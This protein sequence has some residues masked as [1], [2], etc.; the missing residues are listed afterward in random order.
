MRS[1]WSG[2]VTICSFN[3][4]RDTIFTDHISPGSTYEGVP[5]IPFLRNSPV[6]HRSTGLYLMHF[7]GH[8]RQFSLQYAEGFPYP[9][10][11]NAPADGKELSAEFI[12]SSSFV[13]GLG[14]LS[15]YCSHSS[16]IP[17]KIK[18]TPGHGLYRGKEKKAGIYRET[19]SRKG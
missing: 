14:F 3:S 8:I 11:G 19:S 4:S 18:S 13:H 10:S 1:G 5:Y 6:Q 9:V 17:A 12:H 7:K 2:R 15:S 16:R